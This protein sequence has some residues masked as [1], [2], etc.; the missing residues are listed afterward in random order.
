VELNHTI[1]NSNP[2]TVSEAKQACLNAASAGIAVARFEGV[3]R[4]NSGFEARLDCIWEPKRAQDADDVVANNLDA[5][6]QIEFDNEGCDHFI[7]ST[8]PIEA[9]LEYWRNKPPT[10]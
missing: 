6:Y 8:W 5:A 3:I 2:L 1:A 9:E 7:L 10:P 4:R